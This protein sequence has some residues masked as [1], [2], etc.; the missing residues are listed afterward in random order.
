MEKSYTQ[1]LLEFQ[2]KESKNPLPKGKIFSFE[3]LRTKLTYNPSV[4]FAIYSPSL[5]KEIQ[6]MYVRVESP[7]SN[8]LD[9]TVPYDSQA[10]LYYEVQ[11]G[12][13]KQVTEELIGSAN[14]LVFDKMEDPFISIIHG[15]IVFGGVVMEFPKDKERT[16]KIA[17]ESEEHFD[18]TKANVIVTTQFFRG[19]TVSEL[20]HFT[21]IR[22]MKDIRLGELTDGSILV[23]TRPQG[24][25]AGLGSIGLT[26]VKRLDDLDQ[27]TIDN[28]SLIKNLSS[29]DIKL[30]ALAIYPIS[31]NAKEESRHE[32]SGIIGVTAYSDANKN[33]HY[34]AT[35]FRI[36]N[37]Y[38]FES[39]EINHTPMEVIAW[40]KNWEE[41]ETKR[42]QTKDVIFPAGIIRKE[43]T[44]FLISGLSDA[45]TGEIAIPDPFSV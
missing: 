39:E 16:K 38:T 44:T 32:E 25:E 20:K 8:W 45:Q 18:Y 15:E 19:K 1:L 35:A 37:P 30:G 41:G 14:G 10:V 24:K 21:T 13:W 22:N 31:L 26:R 5:K 9:P 40:R 36:L 2:E 28:A 29:P 12:V 17:V 7:D 4:P 27:R 34:F 43:G 23:A 33:W 6:G 11:D 3:N 42:S